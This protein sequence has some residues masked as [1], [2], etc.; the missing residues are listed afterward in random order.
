MNINASGE[1][2]SLDED[3]RLKDGVL[4]Q[5]Q[6]IPVNELKI[7][8]A[9]E[10]EKAGARSRMQVPSILQVQQQQKQ[11]Q[12]TVVCWERFLP[13][14][15]IRV[16]L[17][18]NDD[19]TRHIVAALLRNCN[20]EVFFSI[21]FNHSNCY[22]VMV[23]ANGLQAWKILEELTN[24]IDLVLTEVVMPYLPGIP[25]LNKIMSH[26][27][28]KNIPV[29]MMSSHDSM[30]LVFKCLSNG[31]VDFLVKPIR[32]NELKNLWQHVWRRC[33]SSSGSGSESGT[34]TH[35]SVKSKIS[36]NSDNS[37]SD[38]RE[39][40]GNN[41]LHVGDGSDDGSG[42][43]NSWTM[44][45]VEVDSTQTESPM[46]Q[47]AECADSTCAQVIRSNAENSG[48]KRAHIS[49]ARG[50]HEHKQTDTVPEYKELETLIT[51]NVEPKAENPVEIPLALVDS[52]LKS[53]AEFDCNAIITQ[54]EIGQPNPT[55]ECLIPVQKGESEEM[56]NNLINGREFESTRDVA[57]IS[58]NNNN[59][60]VD[61][62]APNYEH[63][64]KRLRGVQ[65]TWRSVEDD[66][67]VVR[68]SEQSAFSRFG[69]W[70]TTPPNEIICSSSK[71]DNSV[72]IPKRES[73]GDLQAQSA[74]RVVY[75]SSNSLNNNL[76]NKLP[77]HRSIM[78][79]KSEA[80]LTTN[81]HPS[82]SR[83]L[84]NDLRNTQ[85]QVSLHMH[86]DM[87]TTNL[88]PET[89]SK[90]ELLVQQPYHHNYHNHQH[91]HNLEQQSSSSNHGELS[92]EML[93]EDSPYCG[94]KNDISGRMDGNQKNYSL[95]RNASG[96]IYGQNGNS[97]AVNAAET[98]AKSDVGQARKSGSEEA[99]GSGSGNREDEDKLARRLAALSKFR[100]KK[101][102]RC[103]TKKVANLIF[104]FLVRYQNRKR[105]A[106][107]RPRVRGQFVKRTE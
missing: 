14:R 51:R 89:G 87:Q 57:N 49:I 18:E 53:M 90:Q 22:A 10:V 93:A 23:A 82:A 96:R 15:S 70:V 30:G 4:G 79:D 19:S 92:L 11:P 12:G 78:I 80:K 73:V 94:S 60:T 2:D 98:N 7:D 68:R 45:A 3:K 81:L 105:L 41:G 91:F 84:K 75:L 104:Y 72:N 97:N 9:N 6:R 24:H 56:T 13:V 86:R 54:I 16:L 65:D 101:K 21:I 74:D 35:K 88:R 39:N 76:D 37:V 20:Y 43:Q 38:D 1:K 103:F 64:L 26:K 34:Q 40:D 17:V 63:T 83:T 25:L 100:Q 61:S 36:Q 69:R 29:I 58:D 31:A 85:T 66:R 8:A 99:S 52:K 28:R 102:D 46:D 5:R 62:G 55:G 27:S 95:N 42:A 47:V 48:D 32:K 107:Q 59:A 106:E 33:H 77:T 50:S 71:I 44:Q 67:Y